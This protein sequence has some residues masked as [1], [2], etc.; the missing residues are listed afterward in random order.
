MKAIRIIRDEHRSLAAVIHGLL[1]LVREIRERDSDPDFE[2]FAAMLRYIDEFPERL[3]HPKEDA[4]L[5]AR[6]LQRDP[7]SAG[8]IRRLNDEHAEGATKMRELA[9]LLDAYRREGR[10]AFAPFAAAIERYATFHWEHMRVEETDVLPACERHLT[11]DDWAAIDAAFADNDDPLFGIEA[12][13]AFST[14]F[15]RIVQLAPAPI[16]VGPPLEKRR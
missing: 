2:L 3:H 8:V 14:L 10:A 5:F 11:D 7:A 6:L 4:Y 1:Y 15:R 16:G 12:K 13:D 9:A